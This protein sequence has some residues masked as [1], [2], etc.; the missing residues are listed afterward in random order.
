VHYGLFSPWETATFA[1]RPDVVKR[2]KLPKLEIARVDPLL[3]LPPKPGVNAPKAPKASPSPS[4]VAS[5]TAAPDVAP[6]SLRR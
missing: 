2:M 6:Q 3:V 1:I 5:P 4:P